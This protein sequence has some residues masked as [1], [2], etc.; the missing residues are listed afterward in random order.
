MN[1]RFFLKCAATG[2][3]VPS[4]FA[5]PPVRYRVLSGSA[6]NPFRTWNFADGLPSIFKHNGTWRVSGGVLV[7]EPTLGPEL[8]TNGGFDS[9][10][11]WTKGT[12]WTIES[13]V[14]KASSASSF[15]SQ[16]IDGTK[17][18]WLFNSFTVVSITAGN[19]RPSIGGHSQG[20]G[21][22]T[23]GNY[24]G[25][26]SS[27]SDAY[28]G[29]YGASSFSGT[30]DNVSIKRIAVDTATSLVTLGTPKA[31]VTVDIAVQH[32]GNSV[33]VV[34]NWVDESNY[35]AV[36]HSGLKLW[37][38]EYV[39]GV[40]YHRIAEINSFSAN[41]KLQVISSNGTVTVKKN[42]TTIGSAFALNA[43]LTSGT[44]FGLF[45][46]YSGNQITSCTFAKV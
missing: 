33:G 30:I 23:T 14:G 1:R 13:G 19:A 12:G 38:V 15:L 11:G 31:S 45:S 17:D 9:D 16:T 35:V 28:Q 26:M 34:V 39:A 25:S 37:A 22:T 29:V 36:V 20:V 42:G 32:Q 44:K 40:S 5:V 18:M 2:L 10:T 6:V 46:T 21:I 4:A 43:A 3:L 27:N 7:N 41:D 24:S 8:I